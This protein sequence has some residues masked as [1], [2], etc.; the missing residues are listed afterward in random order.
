MTVVQKSS[1]IILDSIRFKA[2]IEPK[3]SKNKES[4]HWSNSLQW[5][6]DQGDG[7]PDPDLMEDDP[8]PH[9]EAAPV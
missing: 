8:A 6:E 3:D 4:E 5:R 1:G 9:V 2:H 7:Y